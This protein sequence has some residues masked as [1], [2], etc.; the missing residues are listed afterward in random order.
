[1]RISLCSP[2]Y[3]RSDKVKT[4]RA[5]PSVKFYVAES[6]AEEYRKANKGLNV[7]EVPDSVQGNVSRIRNHILETEFWN[8]ADGVVMIDDDVSHVGMFEAEDSEYG[9]YGYREK[10]LTEPEL[11][12]F[13]ERGFLLCE[14]WGYKFWGLNPNQTDRKSYKHNTPFNTHAFIGGPFQAYLPNPLRYDEQ[15]YLKEDYDMTLQHIREYGGCL[16]FN[17]YHVVSNQADLGGGCA[18][19]RNVK[20]EMEQVKLL[21]RKWGTD[22]VKTEKSK[23]DYDFNPKLYIPLN[24]V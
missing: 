6:E 20:A 1:M 24:G 4:H 7:V 12:D 9:R 22:V 14:E 16:R 19:T 10:K 18:V 11:L 13:I 15:L 3:R 17:A 23:R 21:Q 2:S 8:G 5:Y